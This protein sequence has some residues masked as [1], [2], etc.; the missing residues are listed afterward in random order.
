VLC[1]SRAADSCLSRS[2]WSSWTKS[3]AGRGRSKGYARR[4][5]SNW[6]L[7]RAT[8]AILVAEDSKGSGL[9]CST[10]VYRGL[11]TSTLFRLVVW[12]V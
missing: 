4:E 12:V 3:K 5:C 9:D 8:A 6:Q 7:K 11:N 2:K 1:V 10:D